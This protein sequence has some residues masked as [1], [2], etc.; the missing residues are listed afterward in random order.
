MRGKD[1]LMET[2]ERH[3]VEF[4][5]GNPGTTENPLLDALIDRPRLRYIVALHEAVA[6]GAAHYYA[7]ASGKTGVVNL[8]VAPGLGNAL[9]M[10]YNAWEA[11]SPLLVTAGQQDT[12]LRLREPLLG[13]DLVAMAAP[14]TKWSVQA[15]RADELGLVLHRALKVAQDP[16]AGPVFVALPIDVMEQE[17]AN[18]AVPVSGLYR[19]SQPDPA[20]LEAAAALVLGSRQPVI[21]VGDGI[22]RAR[23]QE[24][25]VGL[26]ELIGAPV[27]YEGQHHHLD[28]PT[29]HPNCRQRIP[30]D[31]AGIRKIF[32]G[33]DVIV[34]AGG[35]FFK[36]LW[37]ES[38]SPF[39]D[40][41][42]VIQIDETPARLAHTWSVRVG[43]LAS[44]RHALGLLRERVASGAGAPFHEAAAE[45]NRALARGREAEAATQRSRSQAR[46]DHEPIAV[47]R[48]MAELRDA[49]PANVVVV[50]EA[51]T[52]S[53][54]LTRTLE[55]SHAGDYYG[56][57]S[58]GIGQAVPGALGVKLAHP[59]RPVVAVS[60][61]GSAM[62]SVQA[63][64]TAAHHDLAVVWVILHNRE[65]RVLKHNMDTYRRRFGVAA[66]R[67]HPHMNLTTP[68]LDF[69]A[70]A[71][72]MGVAARRVTK[73]AELGEALRTALAAGAPYLLDVV[74]EG[75]RPATAG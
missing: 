37:F 5:F 54:D 22:A 30:F 43:L 66:D 63:L 26:A 32:D 6:V 46:W 38:G 74:V 57:R 51:I 65:Y 18:G 71:Q 64:W 67:P 21:V 14:L 12:R 39:P 13:H 2:L 15:E 11:G 56:V 50:N 28:F 59:D 44:P 48:L 60:G 72:G 52:A 31:V 7:Q 41:A 24:T 55:F 17:T 49:L 68:D 8:H 61:D 35:S 9:G 20:G 1:V 53:V 69:V 29:S 45:R 3:G 75:F 10:L 73:P 58:G 16:P 40:T 36:E 34:L 27:W 19:A 25:L 70:L 23:A 4:L 33:A 62:Y 47:P 42:A